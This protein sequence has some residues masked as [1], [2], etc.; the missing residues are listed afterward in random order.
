MLFTF[1]NFWKGTL[2][3]LGGWALYGFLG[4]EFTVITLL[5]CILSTQYAKEKKTRL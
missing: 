3:F 5:C 2:T 1:N 4:Y